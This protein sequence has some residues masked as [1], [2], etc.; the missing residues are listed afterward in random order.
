MSILFKL[1]SVKT[2]IFCLVI[3]S[4]I[5]IL[6]AQVTLPYT[7]KNT[8]EFPDEDIYVAV[9]GISG[10]HV[11]LDCKT[12]TLHQMNISDNTVLGPVINGNMGPGNDGKY[13]NCFTKLTDIPN[14]TIAMPK[15]EGCR[16]FISVN[17]Q[18]YFY[19]F[20]YDGA[21]SSYSGANL[22]NPTDPN[23]GIRFEMIELTW[24]NIGLW[25]NTTRVDAY[26][27]AMGLEVWGKTG[28]YLKTGEMKTHKQIIE[29][30]KTRVPSNFQS[31]LDEDLEIIQAPSKTP[32]FEVGGVN[33]NY[34][35][36]YIDQIWEK[37]KN[38]DLAFTSDAGTWKG[39][40]EGES[41]VLHNVNTGVTGTILRKPTTQEALEG[42]GVLDFGESSDKVVQSQICAA[43]NRGVVDLFAATGTTQ[44]WGEVSTYFKS[45][46]FNEYVKFWHEADISYD[47][48]SYGF[49][50][51]DVYNQSSTV[52]VVDP[53]RVLVTF[54]GF[55]SENQ[56]DIH[57]KSSLVATSLKPL[58]ITASGS[59]LKFSQNFKNPV[60][61]SL[62]NLNGK[63]ILKEKVLGNSQNLLSRLSSG[64]YLWKIKN[65]NAN[66][67]GLLTI[68]K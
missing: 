65:K 43:I 49:C 37:Y 51:D 46:T 23:Q 22:A 36:N 68:S 6:S 7:F 64:S 29:E 9:V 3:L 12:S 19:F 26:Q 39:R 11:W 25:T 13:A 28:F 57:N 55:G 5:N 4:L 52:H 31:C 1:H 20:G 67:R 54:G 58:T 16:I 62:F 40:V 27:Y 66:S 61:L 21:P 47:E 10:G 2:S 48:K 60:Q 42:K 15:I 45:T 8:S 50:Y 38:D 18:M 53:D 14:K 33:E 30:W 63:L 56:T 32:E 59:T 17:S 44:Q 41:F 35:A 24:D 34:Y